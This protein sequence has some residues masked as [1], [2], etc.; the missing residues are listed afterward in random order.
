M[1]DTLQNLIDAAR[2]AASQLRTLGHNALADRTDE[3]VGA[4]LCEALGPAGF[5]KDMDRHYG[6]MDAVREPLG[7]EWYC[8]ARR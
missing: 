8:E 3:A 7:D 6:G 1:T 2:E 5:M 4:A